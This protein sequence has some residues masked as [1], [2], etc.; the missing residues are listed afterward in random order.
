MRVCV[1][2]CVCVFFHSMARAAWKLAERKRL[3]TAEGSVHAGHP[4]CVSKQLSSPLALPHGPL[5]KGG[6]VVEG[7]GGR[8]SA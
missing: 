7:G 4:G 5:G 6:W 3:A 1:C 2:V 8:I